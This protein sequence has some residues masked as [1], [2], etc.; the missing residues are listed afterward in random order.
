[1]HKIT[2]FVA[3]VATGVVIGIG[4]WIGVGAITTTSA[5]ARSTDS[6]PAMTGAKGVPTSPHDDYEIVV[7]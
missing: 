7:D 4:S 5:V 6:A 2:L 1:M 3:G